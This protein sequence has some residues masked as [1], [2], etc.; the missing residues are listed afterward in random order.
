VLKDAELSGEGMLGLAVTKGGIVRVLPDVV[1]DYAIP[2]TKLILSG[3]WLATVDRNTYRELTTEN[4]YLSNIYQVK[5]SRKDEL[6]ANV[7]GNYGDHLSYTVRASWLNF[8]ALATYLNIPTAFEQ[9]TIA[10]D[11]VSALGLHGAARYTESTKWAAGVTIDD[12]SYYTGTLPQVW[13]LPS[14]KIKADLT[15][16]PIQKLAVTGYLA[17]LSGIY[18]RNSLGKAIVLNPI[19]DIGGNAEYQLVSRLNAFVQLSNLL[20]A[21]YQRWQ[22]YEAYGLNVYVGVRL[23]F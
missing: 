15:V 9:F 21:K 5:P 8:S 3:G 18:A 17:T 2:D 12:Y 13:E 10:Y 7:A 16:I 19:V 11:N 20:G 1:A 4:P 23:K 6:F 14:L 22:G